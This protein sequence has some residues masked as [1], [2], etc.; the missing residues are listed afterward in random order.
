M[1][2]FTLL[3]RVI[4]GLL[5]FVTGGRVSLAADTYVTNTVN[6]TTYTFKVTSTKDKTASVSLSKI[7]GTDLAKYTASTDINLK[8][9]YSDGTYTSGDTVYTITSMEAMNR[10]TTIK[11]VEMPSTVTSL[12]NSCFD[13]CSALT[14][15][16]FPGLTTLPNNC[17]YGC[18][19]LTSFSF[20]DIKT[21]GSLAFYNCSK[22]TDITIPSGATVGQR[23]FQYCTGLKKLTIPKGTYNNRVFDGCTNVTDLVI[24]T[25][26]YIEDKWTGHGCF[27]NMPSVTNVTLIDD[28]G[29][30]TI[31]AYLF[32]CASFSTAGVNLTIP[33]SITAIGDY[34][35]YN[36]NFPTKLDLSKFTSYGAS[37]FER[38]TAFKGNNGD[39]IIAVQKP[40]SATSD[41]KV[42]GRA[43]WITGATEIDIYPGV[44]Y[45]GCGPVPTDKYYTTGNG[46]YNGTNINTIKF[47]DGITSVPDYVFLNASDIPSTCTVT[48]P[49]DPTHIGKGAFC[50]VQFTGQLQK[51]VDA[52]GGGL[53]KIYCQVVYEERNKVCTFAT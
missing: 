48:W 1:K 14:T 32:G 37:A 17:F 20:T 25:G 8:A 11:T 35:F 24:H 46:P 12:P 34:A 30:H 33:E 15:V 4:L 23:A 31:P 41:V 36:A 2:R 5:L 29:D 28:D 49:S 52:L 47:T 53:T 39:G 6:G 45:S 19:A 10:N 13:G 9:S 26:V 50:G 43:F 51:S 21:I 22:L 16:S 27:G 40:T 42:G 38:N 18:T 3:P 7:G 44:D